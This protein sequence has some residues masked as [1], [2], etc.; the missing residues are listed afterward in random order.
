VVGLGKI[1]TAPL[2]NNNRTPIE[3]YV[4]ITTSF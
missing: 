3:K 4:F 2:K 1:A